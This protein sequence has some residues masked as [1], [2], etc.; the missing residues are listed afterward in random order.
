MACTC[1]EIVPQ[2]TYSHAQVTNTF[3]SDYD[4]HRLHWLPDTTGLGNAELRKHLP[5]P[6]AAACIPEARRPE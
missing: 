3:C 1:F 5:T 6:T 2:T 4:Q